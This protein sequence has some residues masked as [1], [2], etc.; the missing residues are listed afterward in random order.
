MAAG[1][2]GQQRRGCAQADLCWDATGVG[3]CPTGTRP[4]GAAG[5]WD[6]GEGGRLGL[7]GAPSAHRAM[8]MTAC[9]LS[10][11]TKPWE[12]Q[13]KVR[14][15][16]GP[17]LLSALCGIALRGSLTS[18]TDAPAC[19]RAEGSRPALGRAS[20][21]V[22]GGATVLTLCQAQMVGLPG[23]LGWRRRRAQSLL[24]VLRTVSDQALDSTG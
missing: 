15:P 23:G 10:A 3:L 7:P 18:G 16:A 9:D 5:R 6:G 22:V 24:H 8:M 20:S 4:L 14:S 19:S 17:H 13:S 11:I 1:R 12:V 2:E 21:C